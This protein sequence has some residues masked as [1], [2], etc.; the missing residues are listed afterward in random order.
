MM[1]SSTRWVAWAFALLMTA[2]LSGCGGKAGST[3][4]FKDEH[5]LPQDTMTVAMAEA[6]TYGG[7]FILPQTIGPKTF[8]APM[9]NETSSSDVTERLFCGLANFDNATQTDVPELAKSYEMSPDG[10]TWT[11]HLRHGAAFSDGH[12]ITAEDVLFSFA[13]AYDDSL[14]PSI[15]DL[16]KLEG[17]KFEVNAPDSYTVV[18]QIPHPYAIM[19][20]AC[21]S[22]KIMPKHV[23]G[24]RL[25]DRTYASAYNVSTPPDSLVTSGP[26]RL[27]QYVPGEKTVLTRNPYWFGV[28]A[29]GQRL[30][31][32]DELIYLIVP[33]QDAADLKFRSGEV[34]GIE[35]V[36]PENYQWYKDNAAK[37]NFTLYDL[38]PAL[39][40]NFF[41]F[42]LNKVREAKPGKPVGS[43]WVGAKAY[44][45]FND[46]RFR[47]AVSKA[48]D[49]DGIIQS[50]YYGEGVKNWSLMTAGNKLWYSPDVKGDDYDLEGAKKLLAE[51]GM[52]DRNGDGIVEDAH[53]NK[54]SF[55]M[56]T[57]GDNKIR[58]SMASFIKDD[59]AKVGI[60]VIPSG[61]DFN[62]LISNTRSDFQY[63]SMLLGLGSAVPPDPAM[64]QNAYRSS[65]LT[66]YWNIKQ[67]KP[68][69]QAEADIDR[70]IEENAS[71]NDMTER[72]R[73]YRQIETI[74]NDQCWIEWMP[75]LKAKLPV[76]NKFGNLSPSIIPH[77]LLWNIDRVYLKPTAT[78]T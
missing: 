36:K 63:E 11:F 38:G 49:R 66:H 43:P 44:A 16:I 45:W 30:P 41:W 1:P 20:P 28:D 48:I 47:R 42:N 39:T 27:K 72:R 3:G 26:W 61:A 77:R 76:R 5:P 10:K 21:G 52:K 17:K 31:Y 23:L 24:P 78:R 64:G 25:A 57:N 4:S 70:L 40:T 32:L 60:E 71:T 58:M 15:Q 54:V 19:V 34:D 29:R 59:L 22:V 75:V 51:I 68:E 62:T 37:Q 35:N 69:T 53:G 9:A 13:I 6:G 7:R 55:G 65:G 56:K 2:G 46:V 8:N 67:P 12:P 33:D 73:A 18:V 14:H 50:A 74:L